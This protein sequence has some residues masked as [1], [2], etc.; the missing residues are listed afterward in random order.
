MID[1]NQLA[2]IKIAPNALTMSQRLV[3]GNNPNLQTIHIDTDA[4]SQDDYMT[5]YP[6]LFKNSTFVLY[7]TPFLQSS[8]DRSSCP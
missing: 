2:V 7:S 6:E 4:L 1:N 5:K 8:I 3:I